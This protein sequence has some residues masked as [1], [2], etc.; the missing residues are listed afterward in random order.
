MFIKNSFLDSI[1]DYVLKDVPFIFVID[2][3]LNNFFIS[4]V[5]ECLKN[6]IL[7]KISEHTNYDIK[8]SKLSTVAKITKKNL[9]Y[10]K[11]L[12]GFNNV[13]KNIYDGNSFLANYTVKTPIKVNTDLK[14]IFYA[15]NAKY[16]LFFKNQFVVFSPE[17]FIKII[18]NKIYSYPMKGTINAEIKDAQQVLIDDE[19]ELVEHVT[20]VDS[21]RNDLNMVSKNVKVEKFRYIDKITSLSGSLLQ[22]SSVISGELELDYKKRL[23][24]IITTLLP[25]GSIT[26]APKIKTVEIIKKS[27]KITRGYYTGIFG[28][29]DGQKL[30]TAVMIRFIENQKGKYFYRSGGG[31][32]IHSDP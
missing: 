23:G 25:A 14:N 28:I 31:I 11:Y 30:D 19:K 21:I 18:D 13:Y 12:K 29:F 27:E 26:G 32:T 17:T 7:F 9:N 15:S 8:N 4:S 3:E 16:K 1:N 2:Y 10:K 6:D 20:I 5:D 24:Q 22:T